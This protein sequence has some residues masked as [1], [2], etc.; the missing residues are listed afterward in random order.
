MKKNDGEISVNVLDMSIILL[1]WKKTVLI[2]ILVF[3]FLVE[4]NPDSP[5]NCS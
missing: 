3:I 4:D 1:K 5:Y 2:N